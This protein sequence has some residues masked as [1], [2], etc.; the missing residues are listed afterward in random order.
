LGICA[1]RG[2][3]TELSDIPDPEALQAYKS[4][5]DGFEAYERQKKKAAVDEYQRARAGLESLY[6]GKEK[7]FSEKRIT[8]LETAIDKYNDNLERVP[9]ATN[10][11]FVLLNLA[12]MYAELASLQS[13]RDDGSDKRSS[14][15]AISLLKTIE[16]KH[17]SFQHRSEAMYLRA[18]LLETNGD[19]TGASAIWRQLAETGSDQF[20]FFGAIASGDGEFEKANLESAVKYY[21]RAQNVLSRLDTPDK[22]LNQL[23]TYYRLAWALFKAG[24]SKD[25]IN[26]AKKIVTPGVLSR[27]A[28]Q[29]DRIS[30][31]SAEIIALSLYELDR[32]ELAQSIMQDKEL[33]SVAPMIA[34]VLME[35][36]LTISQP[37][38]ASTI[39]RIATQQ[40]A[41]AREYP[42]LLKLKARAEERQGQRTARLET[43]EKLALLLPERSLW[44]RHHTSDNTLIEYMEDLSRNA[45]ELTATIY[46]DDG[47]TSGN[48]KKFTMAANYYRIL[49]EDKPNASQSPVVRLKIANC[50]F[51]AGKL[52]DAEVYYRELIDQIKVQDDVLATAHYQLVLTLERQ[53]RSRFERAI[54]KNGDTKSDK[55]ILQSLTK[56]EKSVDEHANRFPGQ[57]RS[58]DLLLVAASAHRDLNRFD[59][60]SRYWQ[61]VLLSNPSDG[62]RSM[63]IRG[64]VFAKIRMGN[65]NETI[66]TVSQFLKLEDQKLLAQTLR[67]ELLG[68]LSTAVTEEAQRLAKAGTTDR[69]AALLIKTSA[70]FSDIPDREQ[71]W[72]DG[73]YF[74]AISGDWSSA[75]AQ[76]EA[77]LAANLS[78]YAGDITYL[79][80]RAHEY[81]M[82]FGPSVK[83]YL[84]LASK[85]PQHER[86]AT[87][88][89]RAEKLA[90]ADGS[91]TDAANANTLKAKRSRDPQERLEAFDSAIRNLLAANQF[92]EAEKT[93]ERRKSLS[94]TNREKIQSEIILSKVRY[95]SGDQQTA[96][97]DLDSIDKQLE[98][99]RYQLGDSYKRL[100]ADVGLFLGNHAISKFRDQRLGDQKDPGANITLK[101][102]LFSEIVSRLD[103]VASHDQPE[104][105]AEA[106][107]KLAQTANEFADELTAIPA[108]AGEP[109]TLKSQT[110][111]SQN[112]ARLRDLAQ[113]YH[114]NNLLAK[115]R[116][117]QAYAKSEWV[118]KSALA[119]SNPTESLAK[120]QGS[121]TIVDQLSTSSSPELPQQWSH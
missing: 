34:L 83:Y 36:Y 56:L 74:L 16:E 37:A 21:E 15:T 87:A 97:D 88:I 22:S 58:V 39:G 43:L 89:E 68:V 49:L 75:Q 1:H 31:D 96:I 119:L 64:L 120:D 112:I 98:R 107:F 10:R 38:K 69:A 40:F 5:W 76:A 2:F 73:S 55:D 52:D 67:L 4:F 110:R 9:S 11:A 71:M 44:R 82:R 65:T 95:A 70:D 66:Q 63:A 101:S 102:D 50:H 109:I 14:L 35:Q 27:S 103:R 99:L 24:R 30:R 54:Q 62:Q 79:L 94:K 113:K 114:G 3:S 91:F 77:Y 85:F 48:P 78:K 29:K 105:S 57:S 92:K 59:E 100:S 111:F 118:S 33:S 106:R 84:E 17:P 115:K 32:D 60:A 61:R 86:A 108:R 28:R 81:Q 7:E 25:A 47:L 72:R 121:P 51:F 90:I 18:T 20:T 45:A 13:Q 117:P 53:W 80:A 19:T 93:A 23:R 116:S 8:I 41:L 26:S 104:F 46:Y 42:D 6:A 12:Q